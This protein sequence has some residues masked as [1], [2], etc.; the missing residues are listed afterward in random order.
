M[1]SRIRAL[2][3]PARVFAASSTREPA[4][5]AA[6]SGSDCADSAAEAAM[7]KLREAILCLVIIGLTFALGVSLVILKRYKDESDRARERREE[8]ATYRVSDGV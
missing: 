3:V 7:S 4:K 6:K 1:Y 2:Y 5:S 8:T